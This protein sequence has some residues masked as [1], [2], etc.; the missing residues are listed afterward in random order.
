ML[1]DCDCIRSNHSV[2]TICI[3]YMYI[4]YNYMSHYINV[5][6]G[7]LISMKGL[8]PGHN[9]SQYYPTRTQIEEVPASGV[10]CFSGTSVKPS[11]IPRQSPGMNSP[12]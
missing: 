1:L 5:E 7:I 12:H 8:Y 3:D 9:E 10:L 4:V 11:A 2:F 6:Y